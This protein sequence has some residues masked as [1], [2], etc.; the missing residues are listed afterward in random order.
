M[1][2]VGTGPRQSSHPIGDQMG[3]TEVSALTDDARGRLMAAAAVKS[4]GHVHRGGRQPYGCNWANL[5]FPFRASHLDLDNNPNMCL[6]LET[7]DGGQMGRERP[8]GPP[9]LLNTRES[10]RTSLEYSLEV[11]TPQ[12]GGAATNGQANTGI[13]TASLANSVRAWWRMLN[14]S[15]FCDTPSLFAAEAELWGST[16]HQSRCR[17]E[18]RVCHRGDIKHIQ[19]PYDP[20][21]AYALFPLNPLPDPRVVTGTQFKLTVSAPTQRRDEVDAAVRAFIA[22][23]G[24][25]ARTR[26]GCG[27]LSLRGGN[28]DV[29]SVTSSPHSGVV[30]VLPGEAYLGSPMRD[31]V[32]AWSAAVNV[33]RDFRQKPDFARNAGQGNRPGRS[34]FPEPDTLRRLTQ[35]HG[36]KPEHPV[37]GYP[38][39]DLGLPIIFHFVGKGE[40]PDKTLQGGRNGHRRFASPIITK[41]LPA[42]DRFRPMVMILNAPHVWEGNEVELAGG[43]GILASEI[44]LTQAQRTEVRPLDGAPIR[45][46]LAAYVQEHGFTRE[47]L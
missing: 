44:E 33:Y 15:A 20:Y 3:P 47:T 46:A 30:T 13:R 14:A 41:A 34:R 9:A 10:G 11:V 37:S 2:L 24:V 25:G 17:V 29:P 6:G 28:L 35:C 7:K 31:A 45:D 42:G 23:G 26:R 43:T 16:E 12:L 18:V 36:H 21:P 5:P 27:S 4:A 32:S 8:D 40:P 1:S 22:F 39:A 38:R 19:H